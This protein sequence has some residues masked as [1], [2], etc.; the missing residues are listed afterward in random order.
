MRISRTKDICYPTVI[1]NPY[2]IKNNIKIIR[3]LTK[4]DLIVVL[5]SNA[6]GLQFNIIFDIIKDLVNRI[7]LNNLREFFEYE[8]YK[9]VSD[10]FK[11]LLLF[12]EFDENLVYQALSF[13]NIINFSVFSY[14]YFLFL[15]E[16]L[17]KEKSVLDIELEIDSGMNRTGIKFFE[18]DKI[19][20]ILDFKFF[21]VRGV[22]THLRSDNIY[23][24]Y[25]QLLN[26]KEFLENFRGKN[27]D[28]HILNSAG[29]LRFIQYFNNSSNLDDLKDFNLREFLSIINLSNLV[30][31]GI[32]VYGIAPNYELLNLKN[33]FNIKNSIKIKLPIIGI[34]EVLKN[35]S[36][37]YLSKD[38][39][40][41]V[42]EDGLVGL[43]YGGYS[44]FPFSKKLL[45]HVYDDEGDYI[46]NSIGPMSMDIT[47]ILIR[48]KNLKEVY[49]VD[50]VLN[51]EEQAFYNLLPVYNYLTNL[52]SNNKVDFILI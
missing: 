33:Q 52:N 25:Y 31:V 35:E 20:E 28:V 36:V 38:I 50:N 34:K 44:A 46:T 37:G 1:I 41:V 6:Y 24:I 39:D 16:I 18:I 40:G 29:V 12:P 4:K 45:F 49:L 42:K 8:V 22:Y 43:V 17:L 47:E 10:N 9:K 27:W 5:K 13:K 2:I 21:N 51:L 48:N 7:A 15:K 19:K 23:D 14:E 26:F 3:E 11:V 30:R 32:L